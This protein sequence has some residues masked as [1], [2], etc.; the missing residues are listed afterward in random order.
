MSI[1]SHVEPRDIAIFGD[2]DYYFGYDDAELQGLLASA[3][4]AAPEKQVSD[5]KRAARILA[6]DAAADWLF[7][8]PYLVVA[9]AEVKGLPENGISE[10]FDVT[11][12]S[13]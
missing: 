7:L 3:D 13:R 10:S 12:V 1:I 4:S 11:T 9:D 2:P 8:F 6:E 5:L